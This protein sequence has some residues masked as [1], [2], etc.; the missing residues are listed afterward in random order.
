MK[1]VRLVPRRAA[2]AAV[3]LVLLCGRPDPAFAQDLQGGTGVFIKRAFVKVASTARAARRTQPRRGGAR[4]AAT[5]ADRSALVDEAIRMGNAEREAQPPRLQDAER[6][7][8]LGARLDPAD[9][10]P[11]AWLGDLYFQQ[12]RFT[13]AEAELR[14]AVALDPRDAISYV[15]LSYMY[16]KLG[17]F[18]EADEAARRVQQILPKEY[19]GYCSMGW[20]KFRRKSYDEAAAAYRRA[21]QLSPRTSGLHSDLGLVLLSQ[22]Q[23]A[24]AADAFR[25]A[26][27]LDPNSTGALIN[28]GVVLQRLG[29]L[30]KA[31]EAYAQA[32]AKAP[33]ATQ[34][35]SNL[36][37]IS[38][39]RDDRAG[40]KSYW[41]E[42]VKLGSAY[43]V[44]RAGLLILD[45]KLPEAL[46]QL[47]QFTQ[48]NAENADGW[49]LLGDVRRARGDADGARAAY[50]RAAQLAPEYARLPRPKL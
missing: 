40:A 30:G 10:R 18:D 36:G 8:Q 4:T 25:H 38:Y 34:P 19:Y 33:A 7:Y 3:L 22:R 17:R 35:R 29:Q 47:E 42:S 41:G 5:A 24:Q 1:P 14:Q 16:S 44:D 6:A 37:T 48:A 45:D 15:R 9:A 43:A 11:H 27:E 46:A 39:T 20:S 28:Y 2:A 32:A 21:I 49:L 12:Q 23:Y 31:A 13:E 50:A 26:I